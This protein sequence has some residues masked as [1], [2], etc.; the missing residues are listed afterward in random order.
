MPESVINDYLLTPSPAH[1]GAAVVN[2]LLLFKSGRKELFDVWFME[3]DAHGEDNGF[4][5][6]YIRKRGMVKVP[7]E[8]LND[9]PANQLMDY[10]NSWTLE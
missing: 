8:I 7:P 1:I 3:C 6:L 4:I 10:I 5:N 9:I 2:N